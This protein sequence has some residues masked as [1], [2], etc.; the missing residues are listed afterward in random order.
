MEGALSEMSS[1]Y[2][3]VVR[4]KKKAECAKCSI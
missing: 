4:N 1:E 3:I 2:V